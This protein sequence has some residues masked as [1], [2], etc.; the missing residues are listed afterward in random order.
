MNQSDTNQS[1]LG[2]LVEPVVSNCSLIDIIKE[3]KQKSIDLKF[4]SIIFIANNYR[5][6]VSNN[7]N[8]DEINIILNESGIDGLC[9][10][11]TDIYGSCNNK[12]K[13]VTCY[14]DPSMITGITYCPDPTDI[15]GY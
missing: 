11:T 10:R 3:A 8:I 14:P 7:C 4:N 15:K 13:G 6:I 12:I 1:I 5:F 9:R 2:L